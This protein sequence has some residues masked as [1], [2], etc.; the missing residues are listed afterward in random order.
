MAKMIYPNDACPC[1]SGKKYKKCCQ[2]KLSISEEKTSVLYWVEYIKS[3]NLVDEQVAFFEKEKMLSDNQL[4]H[5]ICN[6]KQCFARGDAS[7][8]SVM[9]KVNTS[10]VEYQSIVEDAFKKVFI[11]AASQFVAQMNH[12][13]EEE[14]LMIRSVL[15]EKVKKQ[16]SL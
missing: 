1:G 12:L 4:I 8:E 3:N 13:R 5:M 10:R 7:F 2:H 6:I 15:D 9:K 11:E 14:F 16:F